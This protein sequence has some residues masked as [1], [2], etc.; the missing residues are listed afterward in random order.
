[1]PR[2]MVTRA[3]APHFFL[4]SPY[5]RRHRPFLVAAIAFARPPHLALTLSRTAM[6]TE[7]NVAVSPQSPN[8][9][10]ARLMDRQWAGRASGEHRET[11]EV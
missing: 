5:C 2:C 8:Q 7:M 11:T 10:G 9:G 1:M 4:S 3:L 6:P